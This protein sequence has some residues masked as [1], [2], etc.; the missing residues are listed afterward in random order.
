MNGLNV[1]VR[2]LGTVVRRL[3]RGCVQRRLRCWG[4][5]SLIVLS[6]RG[7]IVRGV[8][9]DVWSCIRGGLR[10]ARILLFFN[11]SLHYDL[12]ILLIL[13]TLLNT[14]QHHHYN[15]NTNL[16]L[17]ILPNSIHKEYRS[18]AICPTKNKIFFLAMQQYI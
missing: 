18:L 12:L 10:K 2:I 7:G 1:V 6:V 15:Y 4:R 16:H 14:T 17:F 9:G 11:V 3:W 13:N 8:W 5:R